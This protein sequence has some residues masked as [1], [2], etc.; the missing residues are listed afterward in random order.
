VRVAVK[1]AESAL[2]KRLHLLGVRPIMN[3]KDVAESCEAASSNMLTPA[4][5]MPSDAVDAIS[6]FACTKRAA[7]IID[8]A[9]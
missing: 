7:S 9:A 2:A 5:R 1:V 3:A 6:K 8:E 4:H